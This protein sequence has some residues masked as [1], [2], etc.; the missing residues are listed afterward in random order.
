MQIKENI[1][2][3]RPPLYKHKLMKHLPSQIR[4]NPSEI[5]IQSI[6]VSHAVYILPIGRF[7]KSSSSLFL[8]H[9]A[10]SFSWKNCF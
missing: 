5:S 3:N 9:L 10:F 8:Y 6:T 7:Y 1:K 2:I 4:S